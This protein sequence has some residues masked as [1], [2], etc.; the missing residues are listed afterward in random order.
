MLMAISSARA[1]GQER[2]ST[3]W[4]RLRGRFPF[5]VLL[6]IDG[7][8]RTVRLARAQRAETFEKEAINL[9]KQVS[10]GVISA[11]MHAL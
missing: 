2:R 8:V 6:V 4:H 10:E 9:R 3:L 7:L 5:E 1:D 11:C